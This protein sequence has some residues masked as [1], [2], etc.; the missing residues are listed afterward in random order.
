MSPF[1]RSRHC[2]KKNADNYVLRRGDTVSGIL[3][4]VF[5]KYGSSGYQKGLRIFRLL[6]PDIP[7]L[8]RIYAGQTVWL[9]TAAL[10]NQPWYASLFD[11]SGN[12]ITTRPPTASGPSPPPPP[13]KHHGPL[14][15]V[16]SLLGAR[17]QDRGTYY[18]PRPGRTD[19]KLD[20]AKYPILETPDHQRT[21]ILPS[22]LGSQEM[23]DLDLPTIQSFWPSLSVLTV[24]ADAPVGH[25]LDAY[26]STMPGGSSGPDTVRFID[27]G[28]KVSVSARWWL[29]TPVTEADGGLAKARTGILPYGGP[30]AAIPGSLMAYLARH[31]I[32][33]KAVDGSTPEKEDPPASASLKQI[34][35]TQPKAFVAG[36]TAA[37]GLSYST[38]V[39]I[40]FPYCGLQI[41]AVTNLI[42]TREGRSVLVDFGSFYG[43]A[44]ASIERSGLQ[45]LSIRAGEPRRRITE[46]ILT[47]VGF[48]YKKNPTFTVP[49]I[50][51]AYG[52][53]FSVPGFLVTKGA[54]KEQL[55]SLA[56]LDPALVQWFTYKGFD[57]L[58]IVTQ[59]AK[60]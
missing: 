5:G 3:E 60:S 35:S 51:A 47:T 42:T 27:R 19:A 8:N 21:L 30:D 48:H 15:T 32:L 17:L 9:P 26:V 44:I 23:S 18:F 13:E 16:A 46:Q 54:S 6:N 55:L 25:I 59:E 28:V 52:V 58:Y 11:A 36:L 10:R 7:N 37:L 2:W 50:H 20:L 12:I 33:L 24:A 29:D 56:P 39:S 31:G 1:P 4:A 38:G 57:I 49:S 43:D 22:T 40:S 41:P 14:Q 53:K 34:P 45:V